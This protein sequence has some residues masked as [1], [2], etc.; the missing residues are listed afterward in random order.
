[1]I[2]EQHECK[3][4]YDDSIGMV[5]H[6]TVHWFEILAFY[7]VKTNL[8]NGSTGHVEA[9]VLLDVPVVDLALIETYASV[10]LTYL[11]NVGNHSDV[12][13]VVK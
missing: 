5:E 8:E 12:V 2:I 6:P 7:D 13:D 11:S 9:N 4:E 3:Y 10:L 1:M